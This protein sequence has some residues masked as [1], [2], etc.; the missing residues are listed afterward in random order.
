MP[1][2]VLNF[3]N[4]VSYTDST[5]DWTQIDPHGLVKLRAL[6]CSSHLGPLAC[7]YTQNAYSFISI[8]IPIV[9]FL[10][11]FITSRLNLEDT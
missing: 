4:L 10:A 7:V 5:E 2:S 9:Y 11:S 3:V 1:I 8:Y 6:M